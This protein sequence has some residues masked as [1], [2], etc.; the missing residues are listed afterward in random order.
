MDGLLGIGSDGRLRDPIVFACREINEL[1]LAREAQTLAIDLPSGLNADTGEVD[2]DGVVADI[3]ATIGSAKTGLVADGALDHIGRLSVVPVPGLDSRGGFEEGSDEVLVPRRV[4]GLL[5]KRRRFSMHKGEAG[6]VGIIAGSPGYAGAARLC[7]AAAVVGGA[8]LVTLFVPSAI[9]DVCAAS[10]IPEVMVRAYRTFE[11]IDLAPDVFAI[12]P[13]LGGDPAA[14]IP[15]WLRTVP[16]PVV[17]DADALN[18]LAHAGLTCE[19]LDAGP[20]L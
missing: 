20:R 16:K 17:I 4:R 19:P 6:R 11:E 12:G 7:S 13:G 8:G 2:P 15:R 18:A 5:P 3:T 10:A 9:H 14:A 1:R